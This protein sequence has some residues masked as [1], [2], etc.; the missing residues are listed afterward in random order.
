MTL[1]EAFTVYPNDQWMYRTYRPDLVCTIHFLKGFQDIIFDLQEKGEDVSPSA[2]DDI[3]ANDWEPRVL[4]LV[5]G[6]II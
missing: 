3:Y 1:D 2:I 4:P 6:G 5:K